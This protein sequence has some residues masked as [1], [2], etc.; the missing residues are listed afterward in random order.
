MYL[1]RPLLYHGR[2]FDIRHY[3]II[4]HMFGVMRAYWYQEGYIRT[5]S[6][7]FTLNNF[8]PEVHLTNDAVQ[9]RCTD[10]QRYE[11]FN[12]LS[13][14]EFQRYLDANLPQKKYNFK[15]QIMPQMKQMASDAARSVFTKIAPD[16]NQ[17]NFEIF[18]L[19]FMIDRQFKP[20]LIEINTNPVLDCTCPLL[21]RIIPYMVEGAFRLSIDLAHP[22]PSHYPNSHKH[23]A[24]QVPL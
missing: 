16:N 13:Y 10:Y 9:K 12:K 7:E 15:Q 23:M 21:N 22:P 1:D 24:P 4:T 19:D 14:D 18:G 6:Y 5:S 20:W 11:P 8:D 2:K 17:H 3:M